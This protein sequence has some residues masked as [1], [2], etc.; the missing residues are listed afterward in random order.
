MEIIGNYIEMA[1]STLPKTPEL[2]RLKEEM[3]AN[4]EDKYLELKAQGKTE[5]E[6]VAW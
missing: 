5:N 6:A 3:I 4:L 1:F 2:Y